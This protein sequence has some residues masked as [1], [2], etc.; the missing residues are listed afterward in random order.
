MF[1]SKS[2]PT[3]LTDKNLNLEALRGILALLVLVGHVDLMQ[4]YFGLLHET[5]KPF[6]YHLGRVA[7][8]GFFVLSGYLITLTLLS[9][10]EKGQWNLRDFYMRRLFRIWPM[11]YL[12]ILLAILVLPHIT[13]LKFTVPALI[14][15]VRTHTGYYWF[16]LLF[17]PQVP[18]S[19]VAVLPFAEPTWSVGVEELFYLVI[20]FVLS[21]VK[22]KLPAKL[23]GFI[24][25]Y[26]ALK[27][28]LFYGYH[29]S[30]DTFVAG[31]L[32]LHRYDAIALGC[33][34]GYLRFKNHKLFG[35]VKAWHVLAAI[36]GMFVYIHFIPYTNAEY[37]ACAICFAVVIAYLATRPKGVISYKPLVYLGTISYSFY[38]LHEIG[39][40]YF[41]N[42][43]PSKGSNLLI[44]VG[45]IVVTTVIA[46]F[47]YFFIEKPLMNFANKRYKRED[48]QV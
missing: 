9:N 16:Y 29:L 4:A 7:V 13:A 48:Q 46:S 37:F 33:L 42:L 6:I 22:T 25:A 40:V 23:I 44:Y 18:V 35:L 21:R 24:I 17:L 36:I 43:L 32:V 12:V 5:M 14:T 8:T 10:R 2:P 41:V 3:G 27:Y 47:T 19:N 26:Q 28:Y 31:M 1:K 39:V 38:L 45:A 20:P 30:N 15:D 34:L 11:Y